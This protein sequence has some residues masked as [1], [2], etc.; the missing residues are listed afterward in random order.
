MTRT[1]LFRYLLLSVLSQEV[2]VASPSLEIFGIDLSNNEIPVTSPVGTVIG[3]LT[4][5][6]SPGERSNEGG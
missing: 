6:M 4:A 1:S 3:S 5:R 2:G